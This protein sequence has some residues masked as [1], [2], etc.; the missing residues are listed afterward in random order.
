MSRVL[1]IGEDYAS[2]LLYRQGK[3]ESKQQNGY[4]GTQKD[5]RIYLQNAEGAEVMVEAAPLEEEW[6]SDYSDPSKR[7][8]RALAQHLVGAY[9]DHDF[10]I[11]M[12]EARRIGLQVSNP[13]KTM[14]QTIDKLYQVLTDPA[15]EGL[16][17][18]G[19]VEEAKVG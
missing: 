1:K 12:E 5:D 8:A 2:R 3:Q 7:R 6:L 11:D 13:S 14:A 15:Y 4:K 19:R 9:P 16:T 10:A 17:A 18:M